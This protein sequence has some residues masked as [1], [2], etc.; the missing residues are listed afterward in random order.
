MKQYDMTFEDREE[1]IHRFQIFKHNDDLI[2]AH[3]AAGLS[4]TMGHNQFS[5]LTS[6]EFRKQVGLDRSLPEFIKSRHSGMNPVHVESGSVPTSVDWVTAGAV[7]AV[8]DQGSCGSC[9]SFSTTGCMEG[10]YYIKNKSLQ[11]FSEQQLV[12]CDT[13]NYGCNGGWMDT[14]FAW[15]QSNGGIC[16]ESS[17]PY[18]SGNG[19]NPSCVS[20]CSVVSG[21]VPTK[22]T[23]VSQTEAALMSAIAIQPVAVAIEA[24]QTG[25]QSYQSGV[26]SGTCGTNLDHG[27]LAVGYGT[28]NGQDYW[29]VKNSWASTWGDQGYIYLARNVTQTGGQCGILLAASYVSL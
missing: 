13:T 9:W 5:H 6:E 10:A 23:D 20:T 15:I 24:D 19:V 22:W 29:L 12:S 7:T 8:K 28:M 3:N 1:F 11:S 16:T 27:V 25:F 18:V 4:W 14:A 2:E 17:Y 26:Y 21:T